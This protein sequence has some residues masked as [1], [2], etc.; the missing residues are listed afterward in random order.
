VLLRQ[1]GTTGAMEMSRR[2][3]CHHCPRWRQ[4]RGL[5]RRSLVKMQWPNLGDGHRCGLMMLLAIGR[6]PPSGHADKPAHQ[7][8]VSAYTN[9]STGCLRLRLC[10]VRC[11]SVWPDMLPPCM[12]ASLFTLPLSVIQS[13]CVC[14]CSIAVSK[15]YAPRILPHADVNPV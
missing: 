13:A 11:T 15:Q 8:S 9:E 7:G 5:L 6:S 10:Q 3:Y 2:Y 12:T 1:A 4:L 14:N